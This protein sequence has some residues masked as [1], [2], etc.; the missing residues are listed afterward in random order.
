MVD[1]LVEAGADELACFID[2]GVEGAR[3]LEG[4]ESLAELKQLAGDD[5]LRLRR[6]LDE[7]LDERLPGRPPVI[8]E[9]P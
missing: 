6:E 7:Y 1:R 2:F 3:V 8:F 9:F 4:L 5:T